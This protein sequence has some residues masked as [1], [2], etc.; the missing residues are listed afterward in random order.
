MAT[1]ISAGQLNR[2]IA[3][4]QESTSQ[5]AFGGPIT[6]WTTIL[7]TWAG[8]RAVTSKEIYAAS[9]FTS[10]VSHVITLRYQPCVA[11][12]SSYRVQH[13]CRIFEIQAISDPDES[14]RELQ[15]LCL[16]LNEGV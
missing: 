8:I 3:I 14:K 7:C 1:S 6:T 12:R 5:D 13:E 11:I 16:E 4:Q 15:L 2:R 9:G 10:Q